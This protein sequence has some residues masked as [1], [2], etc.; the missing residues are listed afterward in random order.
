MYLTRLHQI[1][2]KLS[3]AEAVRTSQA[4]ERVELV[5]GGLRK[6]R[7]KDDSAVQASQDMSQNLRR[8]VQLLSTQVK[9]SEAT[10]E[11]LGWQQCLNLPCQVMMIN[12]STEQ[13]S[14]VVRKTRDELKSIDSH[15]TTSHALIKDVKVCTTRH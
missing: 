3:N 12:I 5:E 14:S 1:L 9:Q 13:S 10:M 4:K 8:T 2:S 15:V 11:T 7:G 6:R